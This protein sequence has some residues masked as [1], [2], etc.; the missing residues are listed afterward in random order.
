MNKEEVIKIAIEAVREYDEKQKIKNLKYRHDRRL[1][2]TKL[3][4]KHYN[5]FRNH[6]ENAIYSVEQIDA[7]ATLDEIDGL[8]SDLYVKSIKKSA[9]LT[10]IIL[11]HVQAMLDLYEAYA[12][13]KGEN[14]QRKLRVLKSF[15]LEQKSIFDIMNNEHISERTFFRDRDDAINVLSSMI[16]GIEVVSSMAE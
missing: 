5:Y 16:F 14:E 9:S 7:I 12:L 11:S 10:H 1:R 2:N 15:Y 4:L 8:N 13:N 3:L 6:V